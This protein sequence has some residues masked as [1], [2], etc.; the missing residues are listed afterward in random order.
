LNRA[1]TPFRLRACTPSL[2]PPIQPLIAGQ[3]A[4]TGE[5]LLV[6]APLAGV[7]ML[8]QA[9]KWWAWRH[10]SW[11]VI[12]SGGDILVGRTIGSW[13]ASPVPGALLD[14][15]SIEL[16][17]LAIVV[18]ARSRASATVRVPGA[19]M[20]GGW[21]SNVLDRL[22]IHYLSA[23]GSIRGVVDFIHFAG[24]YWNVADVFIIASTPVFVV[25]AIYRGV[26]ATLRPAAAGAVPPHTRGRGRARLRIPALAG[27]ALIG[28]VAL[29]AVHHGGVNSPPPHAN[30]QPVGRACA[31][32]TATPLPAC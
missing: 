10:V 30:A 7:A 15:L 6:A 3:Q 2:D 20:I 4:S 18:L 23:P 28:V 32:N 17:S 27:L 24:Y 12:N 13:Y 1:R 16:L 25:A 5:I 19:L 31:L 9:T 21:A 8:D 11:S 22:G 26:R 29:G 14:L